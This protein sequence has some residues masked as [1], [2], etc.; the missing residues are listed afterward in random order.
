MAL[1]EWGPVPVR[2]CVDLDHHK[3]LSQHPD[4]ALAFRPSPSGFANSA[5][6]PSCFNPRT[7]NPHSPTHRVAAQPN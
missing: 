5:P 4:T 7:F 2:A 6:R 3:S 1:P